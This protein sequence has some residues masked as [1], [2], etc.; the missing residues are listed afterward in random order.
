MELKE[1]LG[2]NNTI[3]VD[4]WEKKYRFRDESFDEWLDQQS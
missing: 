2:E 1:W 4:I 3:G